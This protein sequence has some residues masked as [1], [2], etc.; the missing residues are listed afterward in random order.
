MASKQNRHYAWTLNNYTSEEVEAISQSTLRY[1]IYGKEIAPETG[2]PH[3]QGYLESIKP[4]S[5]IALKKLPGFERMHFSARLGT[6]DQARDY[7]RKGT[8]SSEEFLAESRAGTRGINFG[9]NAEVFE[10]GDWQAG[11]QGSRSDKPK[12]EAK[13]REWHNELR[14][15][16]NLQEFISNNPEAAFRYPNGVRMVFESIKQQHLQEQMAVV[17]AN[18]KPRNW[19]EE[20]INELAKNPHPRK[21]IWYVDETGG[22]GKTHIANYLLSKGDAAYF[23]GGRT[24]DIAYR[25]N[26]ER[27]AL[28]DFSRTNE[29]YTNYQAIECLKDGLIDSPKYT[30]VLKQFLVPHVVCF[31]NFMPD[32][33]KLS[34]DRWDIR[35]LEDP[36]YNEIQPV[37]PDMTIEEAL[38]LADSIPE[39][40]QHD[41][42]PGC[43]CWG[44][45][46]QDNVSPQETANYFDNI[47]LEDS[48]GGNTVP[49]HSPEESYEDSSSLSSSDQSEDLNE[50]S[51][52]P[53]SPVPTNPSS[54]HRT[55][56]GRLIRIPKG[57]RKRANGIRAKLGSP[58]DL[59][60]TAP[61]K[62]P[63]PGLP[64]VEP[65]TDGMPSA[66]TSAAPGSCRY[67]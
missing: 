40:E 25:Y 42:K 45:G 36:K 17:F 48:E 55:T 49:P 64:S 31:S 23:R 27:V 9:V 43:P 30:S 32:R 37:I 59:G 57:L 46:G 20:L 44:L 11:G 34:Q 10:R 16:P 19:Q 61:G 39:K 8:Q 3:L 6:R 35:S 29:E 51:S 67:C 41:C 7:C 13:F 50:S 5:I 12:S 38:K 18:F 65:G 15:N 62:A 47:S 4:I 54:E 58:P 28:F 14:E 26:G 24:A 60:C 63:M 52:A 22:K 53:C 21:V 1:I 33:S 66:S 2:T 56:G